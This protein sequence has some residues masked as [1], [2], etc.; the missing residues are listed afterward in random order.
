MKSTIAR[1]LFDL[2]IIRPVSWLMCLAFMSV[3]LMRCFWSSHVGLFVFPDHHWA[4]GI[5]RDIA[6][7]HE[8]GGASITPVC[9]G[10]AALLFLVLDRS[11]GAR[12]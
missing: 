8:Y 3:G 5:V 1:S 2:H 6:G 12:R 11:E 7:G 4:F 9:L 10:I